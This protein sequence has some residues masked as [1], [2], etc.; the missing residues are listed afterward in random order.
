LS[1]LVFGCLLGRCCRISRRRLG[2]PQITPP[3]FVKIAR[4][5]LANITAADIVGD[6]GAGDRRRW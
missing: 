6:L 2:I 3:S 5:G 1:L 4:K